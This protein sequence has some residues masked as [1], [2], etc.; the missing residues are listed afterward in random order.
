M[1]KVISEREINHIKSQ[2]N[3][4]FLRLDVFLVE[5]TLILCIDS[6]GGADKT[7][8]GT[9]SYV[10]SDHKKLLFEISQK[11]VFLWKLLRLLH[12]RSV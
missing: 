5:I 2:N 12:Y 10:Y 1:E 3:L 7:S 6:M 9:C 4:S 8:F 11:G